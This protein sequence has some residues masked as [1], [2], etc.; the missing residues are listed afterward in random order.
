MSVSESLGTQHEVRLPQGTIRYRERGD[1]PPIVFLHGAFVNGDLWRMV[2][3]EL[4]DRFRCI[5][6]DWPL[7]SHEPA[8]DPGAD[9]SAPGLARLVA[10][11]LEALD[12]DGVTVVSND[13]GTGLNQIVMTEHPERLAAA[14]LMSGD[15]FSNFPPRLA[16]PLV[17]PGRLPG[18]MAAT[19]LLI[20]PRAVQRAALKPIAK[21]VPEDDILE[22][23]TGPLRRDAGVR[24]DATKVLRGIRPQYTRRAAER[25]PG[26]TKPVLVAWHP[27]DRLFPLEHGQRLA[28]LL[29]DARLV[30]IPDSRAFISEDQPQR[31]AAEIGEFVSQ[32]AA[33]SEPPSV[34]D[35]GRSPT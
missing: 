35:A 28:E 24:R 31:L 25:L 3:P 29:P 6:P 34:A 4:A 10:D 27:G 17:V 2:V 32:A 11:F 18:A 23:Y 21:R 26:F 33:A 8:L 13:T 9:L 30:Q 7:G 19:A 12:L 5:A 16:L 22:S 20:R 1:G 14:V 15:A